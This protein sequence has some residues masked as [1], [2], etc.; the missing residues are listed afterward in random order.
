M[1]K[2][3]YSKSCKI[4]LHHSTVAGIE[5]QHLPLYE[6]SHLTQCWGDSELTTGAPLKVPT[7]W[8]T[9]FS[10]SPFAPSA[11]HSA[12]EEAQHASEQRKTRDSPLGESLAVEQA[13]ISISYLLFACYGLFIWFKWAEVLLWFSSNK[14]FFIR[15]QFWEGVGKENSTGGSLSSV[16]CFGQGLVSWGQ[17]RASLSCR[18]QAWWAGSTVPSVLCCQG[19]SCE[20]C[21]AHVLLVTYAQW[22]QC[23]I[24]SIYSFG[25]KCRG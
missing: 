11:H 6:I 5:L 14:G 7:E 18:P 9:D 10:F 4:R 3:W 25:K 17:R 1:F 19:L 20:R 16:S 2:S 21:R 15:Q 13:F 24:V 8:K 22:A 23:P 12:A